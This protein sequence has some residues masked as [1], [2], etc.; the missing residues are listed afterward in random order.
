ML[1][2]LKKEKKKIFFFSLKK[3]E[4]KNCNFLIIEGCNWQFGKVDHSSQIPSGKTWRLIPNPSVR[5]SYYSSP[6][7]PLFGIW[8]N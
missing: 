5:V 2:H 6:S 1:G 8:E 4:V 7:K 3:Q